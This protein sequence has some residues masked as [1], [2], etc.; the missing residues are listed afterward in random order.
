[1]L[2]VICVK[3]GDKYSA[4][5]VN[6]LQSM[7]K[8]NLSIDYNFTC[9]TDDPKGLNPDMYILTALY[10]KWW[11]KIQAFNSSLCD[12][13]EFDDE[14]HILFI[15]LDTVIIQDL[16]PLVDYGFECLKEV[17]LVILE[18]FNRP[19]GY[20]SALF[21]LKANSMSFVFEDFKEHSECIMREFAGDQDYLEK[22]APF[23]SF[24]PRSWVVSYKN[25]KDGAQTLEV[26]PEEAKVLCFHGPPKNHEVSEAW[27][28]ELWK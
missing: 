1:M 18:D 24:W 19:G 16:E 11:S 8:R 9:I 22:V 26:L 10:P 14:D 12:E 13:F 20:G 4:E 7:V 25:S 27:V 21:M 5:Y 2:N 23:V 3:T 15:D 28:R 17:P 6:K